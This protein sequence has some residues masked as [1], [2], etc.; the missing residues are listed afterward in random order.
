MFTNLLTWNGSN[1]L[2]ALH[3]IAIVGVLMLGVQPVIATQALSLSAG[4]S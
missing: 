1:R 2:G 3:H 4:V